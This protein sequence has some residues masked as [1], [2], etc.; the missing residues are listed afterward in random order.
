MNKILIPKEKFKISSD[1]HLSHAN[2]LKPDYDNRPFKNIEEHDEE[3]I[4][5]HNTVVSKDDFFFFLGDFSFNKN[6]KAVENFIQQLNG[7]LFF[8]KG[9]HDRK[10][11]IQIYQKYGTYLGEQFSGLKIG[12]SYKECQ[13]I[14]LNHFKMFIWDKS[15]HGSWHLYGHSHGSAE[16]FENGKSMDVGIMQND[17]YPFDFNKIEETMNCKVAKV[18]DHHR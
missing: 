10:E 1:Y 12:D 8:I 6:I 17:Y 7:K 16:H 4:K 18:I 9:N 11:T 14:I 5:R 3:I 15:H 13:T 2:I